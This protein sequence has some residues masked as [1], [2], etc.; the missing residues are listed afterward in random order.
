LWLGD[1]IGV[2]ARDQRRAG[3]SQQLVRAGD[4][5]AILPEEGADT[6]VLARD[7]SCEPS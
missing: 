3:F 4:D 7:A 6:P 2:H 1:V 5:P